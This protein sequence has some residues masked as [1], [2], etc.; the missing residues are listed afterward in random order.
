VREWD[1][2]ASKLADSWD[3]NRMIIQTQ[4]GLPCLFQLADY[5]RVGQTSEVGKG[6]SAED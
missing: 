6:R 2:D 3:L 1:K 4:L 5:Y